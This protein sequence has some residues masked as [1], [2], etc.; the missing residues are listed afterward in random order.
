MAG[1]P[2]GESAADA[3]SIAIRLAETI[4]APR[5]AKSIPLRRILAWLEG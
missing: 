3:A 5:A 4:A 2:A 1:A